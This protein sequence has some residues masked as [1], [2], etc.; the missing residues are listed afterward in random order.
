[1]GGGIQ[2]ALCG[3]GG[4]GSGIYGKVEEVNVREFVGLRWGDSCGTV[5]DGCGNGLG[6]E[7]RLLG[8]EWR[9]LWGKRM[10]K[11]SSPLSK[12]LQP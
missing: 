12:T 6:M 9:W 11:N 3:S 8:M 10:R 5:G 2:G 1:M 7:R 4:F